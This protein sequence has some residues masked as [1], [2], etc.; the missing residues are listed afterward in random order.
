LSGVLPYHVMDYNEW[1]SDFRGACLVNLVLRLVGSAIRI[2][3]NVS[4]PSIGRV[5][6]YLVISSHSIFLAF[7]NGLAH[8]SGMPASPGN[9]RRP[10]FSPW[11]LAVLPHIFIRKSRTQVS[12]DG[13]IDAEQGSQTCRRNRATMHPG[14]YRL[15]GHGV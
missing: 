12:S 8:G 11:V 9:V 1:R 14:R 2:S 15:P 3:Y 6:K 7:L 4:V 5:I 10:G 13:L